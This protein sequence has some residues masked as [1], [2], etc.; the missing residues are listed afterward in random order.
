VNESESEDFHLV[1]IQSGSHPVEVNLTDWG[2]AEVK[3]K[4]EPKR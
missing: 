1:V 3:V 4:D 2:G